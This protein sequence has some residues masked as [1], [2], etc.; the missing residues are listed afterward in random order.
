MEASTVSMRSRC[1]LRGKHEGSQGVQ[2]WNCGARTCFKVV[3][4]GHDAGSPL[5]FPSG[6]K[7]ERNNLQTHV[8]QFVKTTV[9]SCAIFSSCVMRRNGCAHHGWNV[10]TLAS[11]KNKSDIINTCKMDYQNTGVGK[12]KRWKVGAQVLHSAFVIVGILGI[13]PWSSSVAW[14]AG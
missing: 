3:V 2:T 4:Y 6:N 14:Q 7:G 13:S 11:W 12:R 10:W 1:G 9:F 5:E 8:Q